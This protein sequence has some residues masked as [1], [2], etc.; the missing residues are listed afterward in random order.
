[1]STDTTPAP[2]ALVTVETPVG[3]GRLTTALIAAQRDFSPALKTAFNPHF[4]SQ[5]V[6]LAGV[7]GACREALH[8]NGLTVVQT[9]AV[10]EYG[11]VLRSILLH[12]SGE[13]IASEYPLVPVKND[14][15]GM[16][17]AVTYARRYS[18]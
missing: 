6:D 14:P 8:N 12:V 5:Y 13:Q 4:R 2:G 9:T 18:L 15:Q 1:M 7:I 11:T 10:A 17:S 3:L 16:G